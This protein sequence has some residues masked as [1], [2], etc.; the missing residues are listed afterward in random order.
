MEIKSDF[1]F[2]MKVVI[3]GDSGVGKTNFLFRF[4]EGKFSEI[5]IATVGFD[6]KSRIIKLPNS[7]KTVKLQVWDTAGQER[8]MSLNRNLFHRVQGIILMYDLTE[9]DSFEHVT[10]WLDLVKQSAPNKPVI[11]VANKLDMAEEGRIV[12]YEEG[13]KIA[14]INN[15]PF[16]EASGKKGDNVEDIFLTLSEQ[17]YTNM[18]NNNIGRGD[19]NY[20][21]S[22]G[23]QNNRRFCCG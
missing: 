2:L 12:T 6:Y 3:I 15:V 1:E 13:E 14:K 19:A 22:D 23:K 9:R 21:L 10:N 7:K 8:Y 20:S 5:H 16:F 18:Q 17:I 11:I 4:V